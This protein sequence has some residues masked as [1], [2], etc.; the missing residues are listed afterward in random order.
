ME[1]KCIHCHEIFA[2]GRD[3]GTSHMKRHLKVCEAKNAM[4]DM[5]AKM[6]R[7]DAIDPNWKFNPKMARRKLLKLIVINEMPFSLVEYTPFREFTTFLNPWFENISRETIKKDCVAAFKYHGDEMKEAFN[8]FVSR[9]SLTGDMWTS[10]QKLGY[11]CLTCHFVTD[12]WVLHKYIISFAM[13][14][15]PHN[16]MNIFNLVLNSLQEWNLE[17]KL[18]S[19]TLDNAS[20]NTAMVNSLRTNLKKKGFLVLEGKLLHFRCAT[21]VFNL[22]VQDGLRVIKNIVN[23]IRESVK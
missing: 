22:I 13:L 9:V 23:N 21:H 7:P 2:A 8:F 6:G 14:E 3:T 5:V 18:F 1:G 11:L 19:F 15:T 17:D 12:D 20:V 16:S 4:N 10:N